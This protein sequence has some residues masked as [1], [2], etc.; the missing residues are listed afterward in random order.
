VDVQQGRRAVFCN[1]CR[2]IILFSY[3]K[4]RPGPKKEKKVRNFIDLNVFSGGLEYSIIRILI[5]KISFFTENWSISGTGI[6]NLDLLSLVPLSFTFFMRCFRMKLR[7]GPSPPL[8]LL[9]LRD[10]KQVISLLQY[11]P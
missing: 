3:F 10:G 8:Q 7:P 6:R 11:F 5:K 1:A 2:K 9:L 4:T